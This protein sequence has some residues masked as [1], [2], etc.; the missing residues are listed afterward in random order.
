MLHADRQRLQVR[1]PIWEGLRPFFASLY[2]CSFTSSELT[3]SHCTT[4]ET[5]ASPTHPVYQLL[6]GTSDVDAYVNQMSASL[7]VG[8]VLL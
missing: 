8:T 3:F 4:Q 7:T 1:L 6:A 2:I 5:A